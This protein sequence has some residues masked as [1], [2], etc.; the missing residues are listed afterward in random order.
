M[1]WFNLIK[2]RKDDDDG[3]VAQW[4]HP[5]T[6]RP[7]YGANYDVVFCRLWL[8]CSA[9]GLIKLVVV[10]RAQWSSSKTASAHPKMCVSISEHTFSVCLCVI[11]PLSSLEIPCPLLFTS[12]LAIS[13]TDDGP[14][15]CVYVLSCASHSF[16]SLLLNSLNCQ[17]NLSDRLSSICVPLSW[18][19][20]L[21]QLCCV[22]LCLAASHSTEHGFTFSR[23]VNRAVEETQ[24]WQ[25]YLG[26][27]TGVIEAFGFTSERVLSL[28]WR[29]LFL[30]SSNANINCVIVRANRTWQW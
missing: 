16:F 26:H 27:Y 8:H 25:G 14:R 20:A 30:S 11:K 24:E 5:L 9:E 13:D 1:D 10:E 18:A 12:V 15:K 22:M 7:L 4:A 2:W 17:N 29:Q 3:C 28:V 23:S 19:V 21:M 6:A